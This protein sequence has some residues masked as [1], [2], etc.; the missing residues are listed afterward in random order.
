MSD[1]PASERRGYHH[2]NLP[3]ALVAAT[4]A[5]IEAKGPHGFTFAEVARKAGV[6]PAA[7]YRH[8]AS[9]DAL[10]AEVARR[11]FEIFADLLEHAW[12]EGRPSPLSSFEAVGRAYLA[13]ARTEPGYYQAMFE[14]GVSNAADPALRAASDRA[15]G[16]L[17]RASAELARRLPPDKRPPIHMMSFHIWAMS[18]GVVELF[19]RGSAGRSAPISAEELLETGSMIYLRGLGLIPP[20]E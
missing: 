10:M 8:F 15:I 20:D 16:A 17:T 11:G 6:S 18:H 9:L 7:P 5:L 19:A 2:G 4:L 1:D 14:A 13:F 12:D 3:E